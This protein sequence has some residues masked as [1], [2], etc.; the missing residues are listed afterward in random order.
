[1]ITIE[2]VL[3]ESKPPPALSARLITKN[4]S[5]YRCL[6]LDPAGFETMA[7]VNQDEPIPAGP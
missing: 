2:T 3:I 6:T 1:V 5:L 7:A 4:H